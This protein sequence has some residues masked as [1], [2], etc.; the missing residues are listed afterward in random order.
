M[1]S[2]SRP[3]CLAVTLSLT[4]L[5][6][7][8]GA[9]LRLIDAIRNSDKAA[10]RELAKQRADVNASQ[11]DG[12]T[13][14]HWAVYEDDKEAVELLIKA[15]A[16]VD[17]PNEYGATPLWLAC[18]EGH[19]DLIDLL[20]RAGADPNLALHT[21]ETPLMTASRTGNV[22]AVKRLLV[23]GAKVNAK[24]SSRSQTALMWAISERHPDVTALL[25]EFGADVRARTSVRKMLVNSG[26]DGILRLTSDRTD[27]F[28]EE[29]GGFTP[30]LFAARVG[31]AQSAKL[32]LEK[33]AKANETA[34]MGATPLVVA[35]HSGQDEVAL[36]LLDH[37]ADANAADAG[38]TA[39]HAAIRR[40]DFDL[41]TALLAHGANPNAVL[42]KSTPV[43]RGSQ[44]WAFDPVW[45]GA[46]PMWLAAKL[47]DPAIMRALAQAGADPR[48]PGK[49][50]ASVLMAV[51]AGGPGRRPVGNA[52]RDPKDV[53]RD[54]LETLK[55]ALELGVDV[56]APN[57]AGDTPMHMAALRKSNT[58]VQFLAEHGAKLDL[59][60]KKGQTPLVLAQSRP[61]AY[62]AATLVD[63]DPA[64]GAATADLLRKLGATE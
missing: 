40:S 33:G 19:A 3:I 31:D 36:V 30:L 50:G 60:N 42:T 44:D 25:L 41:V 57:A 49:D 6:V 32:L 58:Y 13:A 22:A 8:V 59:K 56:N 45:V 61:N 7:A 55:T 28:E 4:S 54:T 21:G 27:L 43:R 38:Y 5:N 35:A 11:P 18:T 20:L 15:G 62:L 37:G 14:L 46:T 10:V 64:R 48:L 34:P 51:F 23:A 2:K 63:Y 29:Q 26:P 47:T 16:R 53:E 17:A 9:D 24:E 12:S 39:L 1:N 52:T